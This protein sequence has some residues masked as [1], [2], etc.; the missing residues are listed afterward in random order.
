MNCKAVEEII[1]DWLKKQS[2]KTKQKGFVI[3]VSGGVDSALVSTLCAKTQLPTLLLSMPIYQ[4]KNQLERAEKHINKL[5]TLYSNVSTLTVDLTKAFE[6]M[7]SSFISSV[8]DDPMAMANL[9]ARLRMSTLY[10]HAGNKS[11]LVAGTGNKVE[12]FG[13]GFF[14]KYGDGG[15][16]ISPIGELSKTQV[17][18]LASF[19][20]V[21]DEIVKAKPTDGLWEDNRG[22][23]DQIGATYPELEWAMAQ[24]QI[25]NY[26]MGG[27][28]TLPEFDD[29]SDRQKEVMKIYLTR[30]F[31]N[32][33]K[34]ELIPVCEIPRII[35]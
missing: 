23:E 11:Y 35:L 6:V 30:H 10:A 15:V 3:G 4:A 7:S 32:K 28:G 26:V 24:Q 5:I 1:V 27:F 25:K 20:G 12:D 14:T 34:M 18:E 17:W 33:H 21:D 16:D 31:Q 9:R 8:K 29:Y 22:D 2:N 13:V 19:V